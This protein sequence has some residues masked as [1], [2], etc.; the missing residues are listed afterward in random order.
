MLAFI[1]YLITG[2]TIRIINA[3]KILYSL[4]I[5]ANL[6]VCCKKKKITPITNQHVQL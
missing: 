5:N 2:G 1:F 4:A 6:P 3:Y